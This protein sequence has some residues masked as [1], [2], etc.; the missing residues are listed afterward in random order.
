MHYR[1]YTI[2]CIK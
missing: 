1:D 2:H